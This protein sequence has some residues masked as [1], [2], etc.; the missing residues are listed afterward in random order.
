MLH[1]NT[2]KYNNQE[3][4]RK[5]VHICSSARV[6]WQLYIHLAVGSFVTKPAWKTTALPILKALK[7]N[8]SKIS[9]I[10]KS[11]HVWLHAQQPDPQSSIDKCRQKMT[12]AKTN[13]IMMRLETSYTSLYRK[14]PL[15][16]VSNIVCLSSWNRVTDHASGKCAASA[17]RKSGSLGLRMWSSPVSMISIE[18]AT[19]Q[20]R[21]WPNLPGKML[22]HVVSVHMGHKWLHCAKL[23]LSRWPVRRTCWAF[24]HSTATLK[25]SW[26]WGYEICPKSWQIWTHAS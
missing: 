7:K 12:E 15:H 17:V 5:R 4:H 25:L 10:S 16:A 1:E 22:I 3:R 13:N 14:N 2:W 8:P 9:K 6:H 23:S 19:G 24:L 26:D 21:H 18:T 20:K 11:H